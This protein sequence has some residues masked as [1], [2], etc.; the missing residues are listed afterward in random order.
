MRDAI[1]DNKASLTMGAVQASF[2][3]DAIA[4]LTAQSKCTL[5]IGATQQL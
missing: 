2:I 4:A 5:T 3:H 1:L